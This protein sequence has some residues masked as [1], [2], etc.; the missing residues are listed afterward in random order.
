MNF[1]ELRSD[2]VKERQLLR[3]LGRGEERP[4]GQSVLATSMQFGMAIEFERSDHIRKF[5]LFLSEILR[6]MSKVCLTSLSHSFGHFQG[7]QA[8]YFWYF[9]DYWPF[10]G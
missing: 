10:L 1:P 5:R 9:M 4:T 6:V 8:I 3:K 7:S 2:A